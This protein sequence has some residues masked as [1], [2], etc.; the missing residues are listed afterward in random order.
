TNQALGVVIATLEKG[1][2][3]TVRR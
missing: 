2:G 3:W 1:A